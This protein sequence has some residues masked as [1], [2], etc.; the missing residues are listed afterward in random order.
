M[1]T[2]FSCRS[3]PCWLKSVRTGQISNEE[4]TVP[5]FISD[6][7]LARGLIRIGD[8]AI[9]RED[10]AKLRDYFAA[11]YIF[12]VGPAATWASTSSALTSPRCASP[13]SEQPSQVVIDRQ[14]SQP[15]RLGAS[16]L[17]A[18][19]MAPNAAASPIGMATATAISPLCA[20]NPSGPWHLTLN[21]ALP[22]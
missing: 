16:S 4:G 18:G 9:A 13:R 12:R 11:D 2:P 5:G 15:R 17:P 20:A 10:D 19:A 21:H 7:P 1:S 6:S 22:P 3:Y 8:E 14:R